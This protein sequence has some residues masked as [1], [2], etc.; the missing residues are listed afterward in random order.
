[1]AVGVGILYNNG[2]FVFC[3]TGN[4][5]FDFVCFIPSRSYAKVSD[6]WLCRHCVGHICC[7]IPH[8]TYTLLI[9][10]HN[11]PAVLPIQKE[12]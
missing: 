12:A 11:A 4:Y 1:M 6:L 3:I 7:R 9:G 8:C 5:V 10:E 2:D